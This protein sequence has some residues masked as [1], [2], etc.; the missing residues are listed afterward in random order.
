M[1]R[2]QSIMYWGR[3]SG[4]SC[5]SGLPRTA[6]RTGACV[7]QLRFPVGHRLVHLLEQLLPLDDDKAPRL[8][9]EGGRRPP[10]GLDDLPDH[11]FR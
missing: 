2:P 4:S 8:L 7:T 5:S 3:P 6:I 10:E 1:A 9:V 11:F